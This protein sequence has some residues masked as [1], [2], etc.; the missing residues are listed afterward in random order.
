LSKAE[1][2]FKAQFLITLKIIIFGLII[3]ILGYFGGNKSVNAIV[4]MGLAIVTISPLV[5]FY[6]VLKRYKAGN[7]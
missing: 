4:I 6:I 5:S 7:I 2:L 1:E 3:S